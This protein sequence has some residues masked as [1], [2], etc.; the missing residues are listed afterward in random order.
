M[1]LDRP[2]IVMVR[3]QCPSPSRGTRCASG[4]AVIYRLL[5]AMSVHVELRLQS[6]PHLQPQL[7]PHLRA[8][9]PGGA[10]E[11]MVPFFGAS[12][13][14]LAPSMDGFNHGGGVVR[15]RRSIFGTAFLTIT[16]LY[17]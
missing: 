16:P 11:M 7:R 1:V 13:A 14:A 10:V 17:E 12:K 4:A 8:R 9:L 15:S 2:A 5:I 6:Q 3:C